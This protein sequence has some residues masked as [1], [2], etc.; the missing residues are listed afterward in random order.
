ME[1]GC[2]KTVMGRLYKQTFQADW[3]DN[4]NMLLPVQRTTTTIFKKKKRL[5]S[6][7]KQIMGPRDVTVLTVLNIV[8]KIICNIQIK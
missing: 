8:L 1:E 3:L 5:F 2:S 4:M 6:S 7:P